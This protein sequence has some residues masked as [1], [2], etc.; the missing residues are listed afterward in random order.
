MTN[1]QQVKHYK[2]QNTHTHTQCLAFSLTG[3]TPKWKKP[4]KQTDNSQDL[5]GPMFQSRRAATGR[6]AVSLRMRA[7][8]D[9]EWG[10][11]S[12]LLPNWQ[13]W[14]MISHPLPQGPVKFFFFFKF[15]TEW[16]E[17]RFE[18]KKAKF[19]NVFWRP[20]WHHTSLILAGMS[21]VKRGRPASSGR[22]NTRLLTA[23]NDFWL[24]LPYQLNYTL[25]RSPLNTE[26]LRP[27]GLYSVVDGTP[28]AALLLQGHTA[29]IRTGH[30]Q[31]TARHHNKSVRT[32]QRRGL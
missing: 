26:P 15:S 4:N 25:V 6:N 12:G 17:I 22:W 21:W 30:A 1:K 3:K 31:R 19:I 8:P 32:T 27:N 23:I 5:T 28:P 10:S 7:N 9:R 29:T 2:I 13:T 16:K 14:A 11:R 20:T 18:K 24:P